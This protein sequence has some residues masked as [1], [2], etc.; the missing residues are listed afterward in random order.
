MTKP[1]K[2]TFQVWRRESHRCI[3]R[4]KQS[5]AGRGVCSSHAAMPKVKYCDPEIPDNFPHKQFWR[6]H[7][8]L[9][10]IGRAVAAGPKS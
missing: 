3:R 6:W 7:G 5:R 2:D 9:A 8:D 4:A 10:A 1:V